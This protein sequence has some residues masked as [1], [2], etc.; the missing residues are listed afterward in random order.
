MPWVC[1]TG[2]GRPVHL[3]LVLSLAFS[4]LGAVVFLHLLR[5]AEETSN[6]SLVRFMTWIGAGLSIAPRLGILLEAT[7]SFVLDD[8]TGV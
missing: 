1:D 4:G 3:L 2:T 7:A 5:H 8:C 6:P